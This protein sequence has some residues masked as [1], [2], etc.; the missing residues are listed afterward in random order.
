MRTS[1]MQWIFTDR[2]TMN[3]LTWTIEEYINLLNEK[4]F[5]LCEDHFISKDQSDFIK[6]NFFL[7]NETNNYLILLKTTHSSFKMLLSAVIWLGK[8][9]GYSPLRCWLQEYKRDIRKVKVHM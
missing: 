7:Q 8:L 5:E 6:H 3:Q 4:E 2:T 1:Y 9:A